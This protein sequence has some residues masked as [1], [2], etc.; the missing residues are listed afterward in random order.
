MTTGSFRKG[1]FTLALVGGLLGVLGEQ[2]QAANAKNGAAIYTTA[3]C[4][5]C[6]G[7]KGN[8][9]GPASASLNPKPRKFTDAKVMKTLGDKYLMT[10]ISKGGMAVKK[11][12]TMPPN[13]NLSAAQLADLVAHIRVLCKCKGPVG[14]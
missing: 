8:G 5:A 3:G 7:P 11:S 13:P 2:A 10:V 12:P 4:P 9:D 1:I 14:K 6:H